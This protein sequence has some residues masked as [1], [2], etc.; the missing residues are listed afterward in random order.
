MFT[1][2][3]ADRIEVGGYDVW[4]V[5]TFEQGEYRVTNDGRAGP[6]LRMQTND[7]GA[8]QLELYQAWALSGAASDVLRD[9][10]QGFADDEK[11]LDTE[12]GQLVRWGDDRW[13]R[14][15]GAC[16]PRMLRA[17]AGRSIPDVDGFVNRLV[18]ARS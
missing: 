6:R 10:L 9:Y 2:L 1:E 7:F 16:T 4:S 5:V 14:T 15:Y 8:V 18:E 3:R 11:E 13:A 12:N 17:F